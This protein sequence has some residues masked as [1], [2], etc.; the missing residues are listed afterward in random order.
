MSMLPGLFSVV[1]PPINEA[2][3]AHVMPQYVLQRI[4][5]F[6]N[7]SID[8]VVNCPVARHTVLH[9][10]KVGKMIERQY[11]IDDLEDQWNPLGRRG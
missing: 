10:Y 3:P 6:A 7:Y 4:L 1:R 11:E 8:D 5:N 2:S 9:F